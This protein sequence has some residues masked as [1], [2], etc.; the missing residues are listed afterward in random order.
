MLAAPP[1]P[2]AP[3]ALR[4]YS[5]LRDLTQLPLDAG[6]GPQPQEQR[7][8]KV[9]SISAREQEMAGLFDS[10]SVSSSRAPPGIAGATTAPASAAAASS[11]MPRPSLGGSARGTAG[12]NGGST[13]GG[14]VVANPLF[15]LHATTAATAT[16]N[17][18]ASVASS[19]PAPTSTAAAVTSGRAPNGTKAAAVLADFDALLQ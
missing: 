11:G 5:E 16:S 6:P 2:G 17:V 8:G 14:T 3:A 10:L 15:A 7:P 12:G 13:A 19:T 4:T 18:G 1:A 9:G